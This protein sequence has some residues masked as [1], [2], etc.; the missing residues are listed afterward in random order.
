M[1]DRER[2]LAAAIYAQ[3]AGVV[4][5]VR[6]NGNPA[7]VKWDSLGLRKSALLCQGP[8]MP[9]SERKVR[10]IKLAREAR[11]IASGKPQRFGA[12]DVA[13]EPLLVRTKDK[14]RSVRL[15]SIMEEAT[16]DIALV[17]DVVLDQTRVLAEQALELDRLR[18]EVDALR[19]ERLA[20]DVTK[21]VND[22]LLKA[23]REGV[24]IEGFA[25]KIDTKYSVSDERDSAY[26]NDGSGASGSSGA[27]SGS[28]ML[29]S[30]LDYLKGANLAAESANKTL[31]EVR[32][33]LDGRTQTRR[34]RSQEAAGSLTIDRVIPPKADGGE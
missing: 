21:Q 2:K 24:G 33:R 9:E 25:F 7:L 11:F 3:L 12:D 34:A 19:R 23:A 20:T 17:L 10:P 27:T 5:H 6:R 29:G 1:S 14:D 32:T 15:L 16:A 30:V 4:E 22:A 18:A 31:N 8:L 13:Y 26:A 28:L